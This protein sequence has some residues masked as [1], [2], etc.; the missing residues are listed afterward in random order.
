[1]SYIDLIIKYLSGDLSREEA[2]SFEKEM[3]SNDGLRNTFEEYSA[4]F[5]L[6]R[7]Q[8]QERDE[9]LFRRKLEEAM[10]H[11]ARKPEHQTSWLKSRW[12]LPLA[13]ACG[14]LFILT[15]LLVRPMGNE[16]VLSRFYDPG[17]DPVIIALNQGTR[18]ES[19][20][21]ILQYYRGNYKGCMD[22][23]S[24]RI[25][26]QGADKTALLYYLLSSI[27]LDRQDEALEMMMVENRDSMDLPDQAITWYTALALLKSEQ[28]EA[29]V[30]E[31]QPLIRQPGP[32]RSNAVRLEKV[33]LK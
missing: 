27:E 6:I 21:G 5:D 8:L 30:A 3:E 26:N 16:R 29:A 9:L 18:G 22:T 17:R 19:D 20:S 31:L 25:A 7:D 2:T 32:Y 23:L 24:N 15:L 33:L 10:N 1:M 13:A 11:E 4:A 14:L 28:R 12:Y